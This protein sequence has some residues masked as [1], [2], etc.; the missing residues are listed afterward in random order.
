MKIFAHAL[1]L[2]FAVALSAG[3][4]A[5]ANSEASTVVL[6]KVKVSLVYGSGDHV[7][8]ASRSFIVVG[9]PQK[10]S[11][12]KL[13]AASDVEGTSS[14]EIASSDSLET[15]VARLSAQSKSTLEGASAAL[16]AQVTAP[17]VVELVGR[18]ALRKV[19][20]K[21]HPAPGNQTLALPIEDTGDFAVRLPIGEVGG[22]SARKLVFTVP[23]SGERI[24]VTLSVEHL[25]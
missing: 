6:A 3:A 16:E 24:P 23:S 8:A 22:V 9:D 7:A 17:S 18:V 12:L 25:R 13:L 2:A 11:S 1:V 15:G 4:G 21:S 14:S 19:F 10:S 5:Q 20:L